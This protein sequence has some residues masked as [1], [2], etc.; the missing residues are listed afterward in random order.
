M[1]NEYTCPMH[2]QVSQPEPGF[3]PI[4]GMDLEPKTPSMDESF[5]LKGITRR[6]S[7]FS[8]SSGCFSNSCGAV[9]GKLF[10]FVR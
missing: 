8:R 5:E 10:Y 2:P 3:C 9:G 7:C 4:C 1:M 6:Y